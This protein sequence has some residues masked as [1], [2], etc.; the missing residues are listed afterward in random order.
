M[1][2]VQYVLPCVSTTAEVL[3]SL[4]CESAKTTVVEWAK[5]QTKEKED[6]AAHWIQV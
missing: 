3:T 1:A 2:F 4:R 5:V 6:G